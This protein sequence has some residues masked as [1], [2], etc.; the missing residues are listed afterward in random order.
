MLGKRWIRTAASVGIAA[1]TAIAGTMLGAMPANAAQ[2]MYRIV[3]TLPA[4]PG[5]DPWATVPTMAIDPATNTMFALVSSSTASSLTVLDLAAG[6]VSKTLPLPHIPNGVDIDAGRGLVYVTIADTTAGTASLAVF[7]TTSK[8]QVATIPLGSVNLVGSSGN[9]GMAVDT[10]TGSVYLVGTRSV[11]G[12]PTPSILV[13][14]AAQ[15]ASAVGGTGVTPTAVP[16]PS[17]TQGPSAVTVDAAAGI[18]YA[19]TMSPTASTLY[20]FSTATNALTKTVPLTGV[21]DVATVDPATGTV[22]VSRRTAPS[23]TTYELALVPRGASAVSST[24][25][26]PAQ[27]ESL[28]VDPTAGTLYAAVSQP[29]E[30]GT[31]NEVFAI[32]TASKEVVA[33]LPVTTPA[34]VAVN[35]ATGTAYV[36]GARSGDTLISVLRKLTTDRVAGSDRFATSVAVSKKA[37]PGTAPVVYVAS[38]LNYPDALAA[39]P[40]ATKRGGPLL[41][42]P[43]TGLTA[44]VA[45][46]VSRLKPTTIVVA[47]GPASVSDHVLSQLRTA[48]PSATVNRAAGDDRFATSRSVAKGAFSTANTVYLA[49][50][51]NFPDALS[52]GG[53]AGSKGAPVLL[54][55]GAASSV[56]SATA[57]LLKSLGTKKVELVGGSAVMSSGVE[58]SLTQSGY[59]VDR[60][61]G[62]DRYAT[63]EAVNVSTYPTAS[64]AVIATGFGYADA[65]AASSWAGKTSSPLYLAPGSCVPSGVLADMGRLGVRTVT[66]VGGPTVLN[67]G[68]EFLT[69]CDGL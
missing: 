3:N 1:A 64:T 2:S 27:A 6:S 54:V 40:A 47:G 7:S 67:A 17:T 37:F 60:L 56:D 46:E 52:A 20:A 53:A 29:F 62:Q 69:P 57:A 19:V 34:D 25:E 41:L 31:I 22:Y 12:T 11:G 55:D 5:T 18:V 49:S 13:L 59:T 65:L 33:G 44:D 4:A 15:I 38:G 36:S 42:T 14:T 16:L 24:I 61:A 10:A 8:T 66:L 28:E 68:V 63:A 43:P 23:A 32:D 30:G 45:A 58:L 26:L 51:A 9:S 21:A 35:P 48:A 39:G 50:G